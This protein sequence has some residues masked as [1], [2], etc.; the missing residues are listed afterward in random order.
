MLM[1]VKATMSGSEIAAAAM[2]S[3]APAAESTRLS[4]SSWVASWRPDAPMA[5]RTAISRSRESARVSRRQ[6]TFRQPMISSSPTAPK[7]TISAGR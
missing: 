2:P 6:A 1:G 7:S 5:I 4:V 3:P